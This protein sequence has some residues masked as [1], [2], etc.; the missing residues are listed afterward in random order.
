[1]LVRQAYRYQPGLVVLEEG[2]KIISIPVRGIYLIRGE[3][4]L[5]AV[6]FWNN[7]GVCPVCFLK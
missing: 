7:A 3:I 1:M 6:F 4:V 2:A 5:F